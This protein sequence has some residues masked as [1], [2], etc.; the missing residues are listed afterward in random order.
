MAE[1]YTTIEARAFREHY[2]KLV[3]A[4]TAH[5]LPVLGAHFF[6]CE[7]ISK[8]T[9]EMVGNAHCERAERVPKLMLAIMAALE[10]QPDKFE[11]ALKSLA[12]NH[13]Y[14]HLAD[15]IRE[16]YTRPINKP[17]LEGMFNIK[18]TIV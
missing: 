8:E 10:A 7:I 18:K 16:S 12:E 9:M 17:K 13:V 2:S 1:D 4:I 6:S 15:K 14:A 11:S 5:D 3:D